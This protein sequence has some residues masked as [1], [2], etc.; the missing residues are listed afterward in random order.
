V[1]RTGVWITEVHYD[2]QPGA[3]GKLRY[4]VA[5]VF[6]DDGGWFGGSDG[7][8]MR[9][10]VVVLGIN[11]ITGKGDTPAPKGSLSGSVQAQPVGWAQIP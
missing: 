10:G 8:F 6:D 1:A 2:K 4:T 7:D 9:H 11:Q 5:S 3:L